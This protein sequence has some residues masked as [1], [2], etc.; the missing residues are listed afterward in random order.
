MIILTAPDDTT[1]QDKGEFS[2]NV[3]KSINYNYYLSMAN[4]FA[5]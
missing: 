4:G 2:D 3:R 1:F 5:N